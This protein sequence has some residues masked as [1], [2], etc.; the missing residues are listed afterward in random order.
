MLD[1]ARRCHSTPWA[2]YTLA[3]RCVWCK[4]RAKLKQLRANPSVL[5]LDER[6]RPTL[7]RAKGWRPHSVAALARLPWKSFPWPKH[8]TAVAM[9]SAGASRWTTPTISQWRSIFDRRIHSARRRA[10]RSGAAALIGGFGCHLGAALPVALASNS[11]ATALI[12]RVGQR[13]LMVI[14]AHCY[15]RRLQIGSDHAF[16]MAVALGTSMAFLRRRRIR[17]C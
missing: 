15:Q 14:R 4:A 5:V 16:A 13:R 9:V 2:T 10:D 7:H 1:P 17:Q 12:V 3:G 11:F 6:R 8:A